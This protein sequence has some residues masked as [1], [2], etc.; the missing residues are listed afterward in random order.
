MALRVVALAAICAIGFADMYSYSMPGF[1]LGQV[2]A[3]QN[4]SS[5]SVVLA[6]VSRCAAAGAVNAANCS[7][8]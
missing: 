7:K 5:S 8:C 4:V 6:L 2:L 3:A 1:F